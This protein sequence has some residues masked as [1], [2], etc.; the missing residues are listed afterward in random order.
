MCLGEVMENVDCKASEGFKNRL[1]NPITDPV[2][3]DIGIASSRNGRLVPIKAARD[4]DRTR[5]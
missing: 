5:I 1:G 2:M 4:G 3:P